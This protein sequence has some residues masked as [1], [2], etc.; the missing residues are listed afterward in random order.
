M[1]RLQH[2][3]PSLFDLHIG[4]K[5]MVGDMPYAVRK[6]ACGGM[7]F[8]LLLW[9]DSD[10]APQ[11]MSVHG[12]KLALKTILPEAADKEGITLFKRELTVWAAFRHPNVV[13]LN[14]ILDGGVDGWVAAMDWCLGSL[15]DILNER[16][17]LPLKEATDILGDVLNGL[18]Y[19]Y[20]QD[21]VLHLDLKPENILYNLDLGRAGTGSKDP[22][23]TSRFMVSDWGI[24]SIKQPKLNVIAGMPPSSEAAMRTFNNMGTL[25]Y[26]APER[27]RQGFRSSVASDVF[28]LGMIYIELLTGVLPF[29]KDIHPVQF[30]L[31]G[32]YHYDAEALLSRALV[33]RGV[34]C[35]I[36]SMIAPNPTDRPQDYP[37]LRSTIIK[38]YRRSNGILSKLLN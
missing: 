22:I 17:R 27:F 36:L 26:M 18:A 25:L 16:Q 5:V 31:N 3:H 7:G 38:A 33:P 30:L 28:S 29:R 2:S 23:H 12:I 37:T 8:I 11:Q 35:L 32:Q 19:A 13:W 20:K 10:R 9:Q 15:R 6:A 34:R 24:A 4:D 21:Q 1:T 14:E